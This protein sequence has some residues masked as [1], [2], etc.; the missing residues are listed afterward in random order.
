MSTA[1]TFRNYSPADALPA[2]R[3]CYREMRARQTVDYVERMH[4]RYLTY[5]RPLQLWDALAALADFVDLSDPDMDLP[6]VQH[7]LQT[8]AA[9]RADDCPEWMQLVGLIHDLG[10]VLY[11]WGCDEDGTSLDRQWGLVGDTFVV[12]C[13][14]PQALIFP[15]FNALNP[16]MGDPRYNTPLGIYQAGCGLDACA[17][18]WGHDEYLYQV[19]A[20]HAGNRIPEAGMVMI[21]YHSLYA[22]HE[23]GAY[24]RLTTARDARYREQVRQFNRYDLYTK[25]AT[26]HDLDAAKKY[27]A[28]IIE[29]YLGTEPICF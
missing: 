20:H 23:R 14:L 5:D 28:P 26:S 16:D 19:L 11:L 10:K 3:D 21:R 24:A 4:D 22:W 8:A 25:S 1:T 18:A 7:L 15:E 27:F 9:M 6:N 13:A 17:I 29:R 12:G 2:V